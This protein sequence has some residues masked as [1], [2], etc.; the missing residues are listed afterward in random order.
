MLGSFQQPVNF[1]EPIVTMAK[2]LIALVAIV[3]CAMADDASYAAPSVSYGAP[4]ASYDAPAAEYGAPSEGYGAPSQGYDAQEYAAPSGYE[5]TAA[6]ED[7]AGFDL[8]KITELLPLFLAV[9]AAIIVAQL[10][11]PL[12]GAL[13]GAKISLA[14]G[15]LAPLSDAKVG[16]I[17][18]I[19][20]PFN[21]QLCDT[22]GAAV[23]GGRENLGEGFKF[24][25]DSVINML[26][27]A[28]EIYSDFS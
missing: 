2:Y 22:T 13:F 8:G 18:A 17:N 5:Y 11:A 12:L 6:Q 14:S 24:N 3:G 20:A 10:F 25:A 19:L 21:L 23:G 4:A 27:K 15:L 9:F 1:S 26:M 7:D 28:N 16:L